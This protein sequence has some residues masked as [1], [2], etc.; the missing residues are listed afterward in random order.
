MNLSPLYITFGKHQV[1][2][3]TPIVDVHT[4]LKG[5][6]HAMLE[7]QPSLVVRQVI[8]TQSA[9]NYIIQSGEIVHESTTEKMWL[10]QAVKYEVVMGLV[11]ARPD[12]LWFHAGAVAND[13]Q[14][15]VF[16][17]P[18]GGGKSTL[19]TQLYQQGWRYLSDDVLPLELTTGSILPFPQTPRVRQNTGELV[20][21]DR[22]SELPKID[23]TLDLAVICRLPLPIG[24]MVFPKF[25]RHTKA[26]ILPCSPGTA[27]LEL[28]RNC[29]NFTDHKQAA[30]QQICEI[31]KHM[32][33]FELSFSNID[34]ALKCL[35]EIGLGEFPLN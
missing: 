15:V 28:L 3:D 19:V 6:F 4:T 14:A 18:G 17:A 24:A 30:V 22:L 13:T 32:P 33:A 21:S 7:P 9:G 2:V 11:Q 27:A 5:W 20:P 23:V 16:A 25:D 10:L 26:E 12:L 31:V 35:A 34:C 29:I 8:I 1:M